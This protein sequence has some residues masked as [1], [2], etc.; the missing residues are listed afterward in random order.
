MAATLLKDVRI[1]QDWDYHHFGAVHTLVH[2]GVKGAGK[3]DQ[4]ATP[5]MER[6]IKTEPLPIGTPGKTQS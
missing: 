6:W 5:A 3:S 2:P 4:R 1:R